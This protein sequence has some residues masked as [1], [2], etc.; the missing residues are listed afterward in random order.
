MKTES[1]TLI[2]KLEDLDEDCD[3]TIITNI[4]N[5][6]TNYTSEYARNRAGETIAKY[7][8]ALEPTNFNANTEVH[9]NFTNHS[10]IIMTNE[11]AYIG[12]SNYS[13]MS[14]KN[15][16]S[17]VLIKDKSIVEDINSHLLPLFVD[18]SIEYFGSE[19]TRVLV[20]LSNI[21]SK[22]DNFYTEFHMSFYEEAGHS[23]LQGQEYYMH[24][25]SYLSKQLIEEVD[26]MIEELRELIDELDASER[27]ALLFESFDISILDEIED[28][29]GHNSGLYEFSEIDDQSI[30]DSYLEEHYAE[31]FDENLDYYAEQAS[32]RAS[33]IRSEACEQVHD[34]VVKVDELLY[35]LNN[36]IVNIVSDFKSIKDRFNEV[37]NTK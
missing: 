12:S 26:S 13:D 25:S 9:F 29:I 37:D 6:W 24:N 10:K 21:L 36:D 32:Q 20:R 11:M 23:T 3:L 7:I 17:G 33:D 31:A 2:Q 16:E 27:Y 8:T 14:S 22:A 4:P 28:L 34:D 1:S 35:K 15:I 18:T 30:M 5:R 19:D